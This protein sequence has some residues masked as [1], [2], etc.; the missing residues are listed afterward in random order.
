MIG[1][2]S[3]PEPPHGKA[4]LCCTCYW[5]ARLS[6]TATWSVSSSQAVLFNGGFH[7]SLD[8][9]MC[10]GS[11]FWQ[12]S[13]HPTSPTS[14]APRHGPEIQ[15][16]LQARRDAAWLL[17]EVVDDQR[18]CGWKHERD[19]DVQ[20]ITYTVYIYICI[21]TYIYIY[22][23]VDIYIY[24]YIYSCIYIYIYRSLSIYC[25]GFYGVTIE[26]LCYSRIV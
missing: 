4:P 13:T 6:P 23:H 14:L 18:R 15:Q 24:I 5:L 25:C 9:L 19:K 20:D 8:V 16:E 11:V 22:I 26:T 10:F 7:N 1:A 12:Q 3:W 17:L 21:Y 2:D